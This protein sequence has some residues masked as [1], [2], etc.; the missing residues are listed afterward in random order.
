[1]ARTIQFLLLVQLDH[2]SHLYANSILCVHVHD[3]CVWVCVAWLS[4]EG[5][6][7]TL[8]SHLSPSAWSWLELRLVPWSTSWQSKLLRLLSHLAGSGLFF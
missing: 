5:N 8:G 1:M 3:V 7:A 6:M 4:W 2:F